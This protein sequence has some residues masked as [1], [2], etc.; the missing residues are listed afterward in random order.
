MC[1]CVMQEYT[2][3]FHTIS[4]KERGWRSAIVGGTSDGVTLKSIQ[5]TDDAASVSHIAASASS[6]SFDRQDTAS[7]KAYVT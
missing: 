1:V 3:E 4:R 5:R 6:S 2:D 7:V